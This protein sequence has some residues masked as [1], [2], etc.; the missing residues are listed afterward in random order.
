M[1]ILKLITGIFTGLMTCSSFILIFTEKLKLIFFIETLIFGIITYLLIKSTKQKDKKIQVNIPKE[2]LNDLKETYDK[3]QINNIIRIIQE[4]YKIML[5][6][7]DI[8]TLCKRYELGMQKI[9]TLKE[10]EKINMYN[11]EPTADYF[12]SL[13][14]TNYN[15]LIKE[16]HDRYINEVKNKKSK[17]TRENNFWITLSKYVDEYTLQD[18]KN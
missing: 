1:K 5:N 7:K 10:L 14:T 15:K 12:I 4:S 18:L 13:F 3:S 17:E 6:T 2:T 16:C 9:Y 8:E 11:K